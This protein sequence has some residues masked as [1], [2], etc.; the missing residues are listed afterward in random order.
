MAWLWGALAFVGAA[1]AGMLLS[2]AH[3]SASVLARFIVRHSARRLAEPMRSI[4]EEEWLAELEAMEGLH[5]VRL[6]WALHTVAAMLRSPSRIPRRR[7]AVI[8]PIRSAEYD[9]GQ[10]QGTAHSNMRGSA[11]GSIQL[12]GSVGGDGTW[13][14][15]GRWLDGFV[16]DDP[17]RWIT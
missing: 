16:D 1:V 6:L 15:N 14:G 5:I 12:H 10:A 8:G 11:H 2:E 17:N 7:N 4:R 9:D 3:E 13:A